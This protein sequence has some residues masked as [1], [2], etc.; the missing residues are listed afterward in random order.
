VVSVVVPVRN[1]EGFLGEQLE[2]LARQTY[3]GAWEVIISDNASTDGTV[4][5][6]RTFA[7]RLPGLVVVDAGGKRGASHA[8]NVGV[9]RA[10]GALLLFCDAD[11]VTHPDWVGGMVEASG[12]GD[13]I[14]GTWEYGLLNDTDRQPWM[15]TA[16]E[17]RRAR[18]HKKRGFMPY[19]PGGNCGV[20]RDVVEA[21][22]GWD[23]EFDR[24]VEDVDFC[25]RAQLRSFEIVT[26]ETA[27]IHIRLRSSLADF[28]RQVWRDAQS[29]PQLY[30]RFRAHGMRR[31]SVLVAIR[32]W[33]SLVFRLPWAI[34]SRRWRAI[35]VR[36]AAHVLGRLR[37]SIR[38]RTLYL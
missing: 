37:G 19:V 24:G 10:S 35:W 17:V 6:A 11:D 12:E 3:V 7:D 15:S 1:A 38:C 14:R 29:A 36:R 33:G 5:I 32:T 20:W 18:E 28:A 34:G 21:L 16:E 9:E 4:E 23:E 8:R 25:W 26:A 30:A 2:S 22:A 27:V 31:S 13:L